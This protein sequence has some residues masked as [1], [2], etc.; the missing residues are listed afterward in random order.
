MDSNSAMFEAIEKI[1]ETLVNLLI[2][3]EHLTNNEL[4]MVANSLGAAHASLQN[5]VYFDSFLL[6]LRSEALS[7]RPGRRRFNMKMM[8]WLQNRER[9]GVETFTADVIE[10]WKQTH[11]T[12]ETPT[13]EEL[14]AFRD[15]NS[16]WGDEE[17]GWNLIVG[18]SLK[19]NH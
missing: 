4:R 9:R 1:K 3:N 13:Q 5:C 2:D 12:N 19:R 7:R 18:W 16:I 17:E 14:E 15:V 11:W 10:K 8:R 6:D